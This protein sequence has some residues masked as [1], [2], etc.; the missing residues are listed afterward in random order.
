M[1]IVGLLAQTRC[2]IYQFHCNL[3]RGLAERGCS[4]TWLCSGLTHARLVATDGAEPTEGEV[5]APD[6]DDLGIRTRALVER[7]EEISPDAILCHGVGDRIDFNAIRYMPE[8]I[9]KALILHGSTLAVYRC[10][11]AVRDYV[12]TTVAISPRIEQ[13]LVR[14]YEF[15]QKKIRLVPHGIDAAAYADSPIRNSESGPLRILSHGR[16]PLSS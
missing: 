7:I 2:G 8:S 3:V 4:V 13:D 16:I 15:D 9:P 5:V 11:R 1:R 14:T 10:A 12:S 6:T